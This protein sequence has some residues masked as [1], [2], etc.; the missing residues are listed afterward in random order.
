[1]NYRLAFGD[2]TQPIPLELQ[3]SWENRAEWKQTHQDR[4]VQV[5]SPKQPCGETD[6]LWTQERNI[7]IAV[8]TADCVPIV[9]IAKRSGNQNAL[10]IAAVHAG[11]RGTFARI[12]QKTI[13]SINQDLNLKLHWEAHI[14]PCIGDCCYDVSDEIATQFTSEFNKS[15]DG[16]FSNSFIEH[17]NGRPF[18]NLAKVNELQLIEAGV[19]EITHSALCTRCS[20]KRFF[21]YRGGDL[22]ARQ[23]SGAVLL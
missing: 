18:L 11:W 3:P 16:Y 6:S 9:L 12:V 15:S 23:Y 1:M 13:V 5:T 22:T 7:P 2:R 19:D 8:V 21:S 4:T 17:K 10:A 20:E 14:G